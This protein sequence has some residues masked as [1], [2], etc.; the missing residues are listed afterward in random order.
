MDEHK[1]A[2]SIADAARLLGVGRTT[3]YAT[4]KQGNLKTCKIG[5]RTL[6]TPKAIQDL[7][8][9]LPSSDGGRRSTGDGGRDD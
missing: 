7:L 6:L 4:I 3:L 5:R 8:C 2:Y 9:K 1:F